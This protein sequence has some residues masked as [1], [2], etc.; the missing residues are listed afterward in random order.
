MHVPFNGAGPS[1]A[2]VV[3]GH[4]PIGFS[5]IASAGPHINDGKLRALAVTAK[6]R[7]P[8]QPDVPTMTEAGYPDIEGDS[9]VGV[10]VPAGTP[11][12]L[13][14]LLHDEIVRII[15]LPDIRERLKTLGSDVVASTPQDFASRINVEI[16][17][18]GQIIRAGNVKPQ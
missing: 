8:I 11:K 7:T 18:W 4:T 13:V 1:I 17:T 14:G 2:S 6:V 10:M 12:D 9:W 5:T 15:Q 3:A 16:E